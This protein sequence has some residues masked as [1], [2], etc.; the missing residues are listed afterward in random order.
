MKE[1]FKSLSTTLNDEVF[2]SYQLT[3]D[4]QQTPVSSFFTN[5]VPN[6]QKA[7]KSLVTNVLQQLQPGKLFQSAFTDSAIISSA[8]YFVLNL[9]DSVLNVL[10][11]SHSLLNS[12]LLGIVPN[13]AF[14]TIHVLFEWSGY[15]SVSLY[16]Q[17]LFYVLGP[18]VLAFGYQFMKLDHEEKKWKKKFGAEYNGV[19]IGQKIVL[20]NIKCEEKLE[21]SDNAPE[22]VTSLL[23]KMI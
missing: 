3:C 21:D 9:T 13:L 8:K 2:G 17:M 22:Y 14:N 15:I 20:Q 6:V 7:V 12:K 10:F 23:F 19:T 5:L 18:F 16:L 4:A 11:G 1:T